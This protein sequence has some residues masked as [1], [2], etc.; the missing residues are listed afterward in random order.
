MYTPRRRLPASIEDALAAVSVDVD[1]D[2]AKV[3]SGQ[4]E[5][6]VLMAVAM[7]ADQLARGERPVHHPSRWLARTVSSVRAR[8]LEVCMFC[9]VDL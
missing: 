8:R 4:R 1:D 7:L 3:L 2:C 5:S 6:H 9:F